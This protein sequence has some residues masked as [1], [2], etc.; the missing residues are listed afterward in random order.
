VLEGA[1]ISIS[2]NEHDNLLGVQNNNYSTKSSG[3]TEDQQKI[4]DSA[5]KFEEGKQLSEEYKASL[6][7][8]AE[9]EQLRRNAPGS[10]LD[11][12]YPDLDETIAL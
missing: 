7:A 5:S 8:L 11:E 2:G 1:K 4:V 9:L 6:G 12:Y 10:F 3:F